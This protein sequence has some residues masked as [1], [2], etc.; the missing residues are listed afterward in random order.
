MSKQDAMNLRTEVAKGKKAT[1]IYKQFADGK[2]GKDT[3]EDELHKINA[4]GSAFN[5]KLKRIKITKAVKKTMPDS[6]SKQ[7]SIKELQARYNAE[8]NKSVDSQINR[9]VVEV[10]EDEEE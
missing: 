8:N 10:L 3:L 1:D 4:I 9:S 2:F 7:L 5:V 6:P